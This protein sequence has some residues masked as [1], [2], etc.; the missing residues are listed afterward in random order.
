MRPRLARLARLSDTQRA[1]ALSGAL[2]ACSLP[3]LM[4]ERDRRLFW[5]LVVAEQAKL[6]AAFA[7]HHLVYRLYGDGSDAHAYDIGARAIA[8]RLRSG[9]VRGVVTLARTVPFDTGRRPPVGTNAIRLAGGAVYAVTGS[10][11]RCGFVVF[12]WMGFWG[13]YLFGRALRIAV[14]EHRARGY[15]RLVFLPSVV[16]WTSMIGKEAWMVFSLGLGSVGVARTLVGPRR[17]GVPLALAGAGLAAAARPHTPAMLG[18]GFGAAL[19]ADTERT[20]VGASRFDPPA[21]R[22]PRDLPRVAASVLFRP[23]PLEAHN[24]SAVAS[25]VEGAAVVALSIVRVRWIATALATAP[26]RPYVGFSLASTGILVAMLARMSNLGLLAR[27][28]VPVMP[29]YLVLLS[30]PPRRS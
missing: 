13:L 10:S 27:Q 20:A 22:G 2:F 28:R 12:S 4:R 15:A 24:A 14:P 11:S 9:T 6:G 7:S 23:H 8:E 3:V 29:F 21:L 30:I 5:T 25:A 16:F 17:V 26:R 19:E 1:V 18:P